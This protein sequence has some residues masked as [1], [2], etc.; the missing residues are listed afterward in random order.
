MEI[1]VLGPGCA[2]CHNLEKLTLTVLQELGIEANVE[3]ITNI[4]EIAKAG[5]LMTPGLIID[6]KIKLSG[7]VPSKTELT[8]IIAAAQG[9][10]LA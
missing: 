7:K 8:K 4:K 3:K 1:K 6:G 10:E 2:N 9:N 5:I